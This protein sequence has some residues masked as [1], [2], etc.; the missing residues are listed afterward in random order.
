MATTAIRDVLNVGNKI[1]SAELRQVQ[2]MFEILPGHQATLLQRVGYG[3]AVRFNDAMK[4]EWVRDEYLPRYVTVNNGAGYSDSDTSI[5]VDEADYIQ[6]GQ[7]LKNGGET[8][9]VTSISSNTLTVVR[10]IGAGAGEAIADNDPLLVLPPNY[11]D[12]DEFVVT[13]TLRGETLF[14]YPQ[15]IMYSFSETAMSSGRYN[16]LTGGVEDLVYSERKHMIDAAKRLEAGIFYNQKVQPTASVQGAFDGIDALITDNVNSAVG[17]LTPTKIVNLLDL[18]WSDAGTTDGIDIYMNHTTKRIW[19]AIWR[20]RFNATIEA[21]TTSIGITMERV[22]W[23]GGVMNVILNHF[24]E[25]GDIFFLRT[26]KMKILPMDVRLEGLGSGWQRGTR[27]VENLNKLQTT[28]FFYGI[29]TF[30]I[31]EERLHG[32]MKAVTVDPTAYEG[33]V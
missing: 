13:P 11:L 3:S 24:V 26:D 1:S 18:I 2:D 7:V 29:F 31:Q 19:D 17:L 8:M 28:V 12:T 4:F 5:V 20:N 21:E 16:Y 22:R 33:V 27:S 14:N 30:I 25:D 10:S 15:Q 6:A 9:R 32:K 23:N